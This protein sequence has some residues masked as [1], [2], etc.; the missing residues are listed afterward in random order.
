MSNPITLDDLE[1]LHAELPPEYLAKQT[2]AAQTEDP[3]LGW[4]PLGAK[5]VEA[6]RT[7]V[8]TGAS[9][10][11]RAPEVK[12][13][14]LTHHRLA[15]LL[16]SGMKDNQAALLCGFTPNR[17]SILRQSPAFQEILAHYA[18][19]VDVKFREWAESAADLSSDFLQ[20]LQQQLDESPEKFTPTVT[21]EAIRTLADRTGNGPQTKNL[22]VNINTDI[23]GRM[24]RAKRRLAER[25]TTDAVFEEVRNALPER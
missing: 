12:N 9:L 16:A 20:H 23:A 21:L 14:R 18:T 4:E 5:H 7:Y 24:E 22:N 8:E 6:I 10:N 2:R 1:S 3:F 13:I 17:V 15:Q 25:N 19:E 11:V